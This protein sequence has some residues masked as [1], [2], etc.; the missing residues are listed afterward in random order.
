M[1]VIRR[2]MKRINLLGLQD[3]F[4]SWLGLCAPGIVVLLLSASLDINTCRS[5]SGC[6]RS[7][8]SD[9]HCVSDR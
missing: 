1:R 6:H 5:L 2:D 7:V 9:A 8:A 4:I 3:I